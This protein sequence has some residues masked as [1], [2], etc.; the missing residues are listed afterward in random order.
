MKTSPVW[1]FDLDNTL[2]NAS[3]HIFPRI[4]DAMTAYMA[5]HLE[6]DTQTADHLRMKY[7]YRYGATLLGLMRH[8]GTNPH[9]FLHHT[10]QFENLGEL[11]VFDRALLAHLRRLPGRRYLFSNAPREYL[12]AL[13]HLTGLD[14]VLHGSFSIEDL[15][16]HPKPQKLAYLIALRK[17]GVKPRHC[18]LVEDTASNLREAKRLGIRTVW[19]SQTHVRPAWVDQ[20]LGSVRELRVPSR[21]IRN[22]P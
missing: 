3:A 20:R 2:H 12:D 8:H 14:R 11:V 9:H 4:N 13:L 22:P 15:G 18:I 21:M 17:L 10:H 7:W 1:L 19:I 6:L 16:F 5:C